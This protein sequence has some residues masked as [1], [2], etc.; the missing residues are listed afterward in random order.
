MIT[1]T[2]VVNIPT[3]MKTEFTKTVTQP[4]GSY[5]M[6]DSHGIMDAGMGGGS[7]VTGGTAPTSNGQVKM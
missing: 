7:N 1:A 4:G 2:K 3:N 5:T 6:G